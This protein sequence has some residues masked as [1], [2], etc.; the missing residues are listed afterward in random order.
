MGS[1]APSFV[2]CMHFIGNLTKHVENTGK[3]NFMRYL[4]YKDL[5]IAKITKSAIEDL[6][7]KKYDIAAYIWPSYHYEPRMAHVWTEEDGEW[8]T[9]RNAKPKFDG[10]NQPRIPVLGYQDEADPSVM[11][12][13][14][15][16][17]LEHGVNVFIMDWYWYDDQ[18][19]LETQ[20][21]KGLMPAVKGTDMK[22]YIMWA[23]H[24]ANSVWDPKTDDM[25][26]YWDGGVNREIFEKIALRWIKKYFTHENYYKID[27]K[28]VFCLYHLPTFIDGIGSLEDAVD[29]LPDEKWGYSYLEAVKSVFEY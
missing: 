19:F 16:L 24:D 20:F 10:H 21:N 23:N 26:P 22:F 17:A 29:A 9:V 6:S 5:R 27:E 3:F 2:D 11:K 25:N 4:L 14:T 28:P 12:Q 13:H 8:T 15:E 18:P 1:S 7:V